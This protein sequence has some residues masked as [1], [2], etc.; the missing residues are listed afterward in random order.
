MKHAFLRV[1]AHRNQI[2][3]LN[4]CVS[5]AKIAYFPLIMPIPYLGVKPLKSEPAA[6][7]LPPTSPPSVQLFALQGPPVMH[8]LIGESTPAP[9]GISRCIG[10]VDF[11]LLRQFAS[12]M[13]ANVFIKMGSDVWADRM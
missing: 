2:S 8:L 3:C 10:A 4:L 5:P 9:C 12:V 13:V 11:V 6:P 1:H 7:K